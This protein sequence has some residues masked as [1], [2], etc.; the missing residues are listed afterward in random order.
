MS[1]SS[2]LRL[3]PNL[4]KQRRKNCEKRAECAVSSDQTRESGKSCC[5]II[6]NYR[7]L[8]DII[9]NYQDPSQAYQRLI[10]LI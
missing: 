5:I 7:M 4:V 10:T 6:N 9:W 2:V 3:H 8:F 1:R